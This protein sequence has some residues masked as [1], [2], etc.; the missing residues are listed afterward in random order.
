MSLTVQAEGEPRLRRHEDRGVVESCL[1]RAQPI[2]GR[3]GGGSAGDSR[4]S[5]KPK[6]CIAWAAGGGIGGSFTLKRVRRG[7][8]AAAVQ[9]RRR[10]RALPAAGLKLGA[11]CSHLPGTQN[12]TDNRH[13]A[14]ESLC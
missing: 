3:L 12:C 11:C 10:C 13:P 14:R 5:W 9:Q 1:A 8:C 6:A 2:R 4:G 7:S